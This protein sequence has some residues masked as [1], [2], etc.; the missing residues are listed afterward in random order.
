MWNGKTVEHEVL[1]GGLSN[2][3]YTCCV[4][5]GEKYVL[6]IPGEETDLFIDRTNEQAAIRA[7][8]GI[9]VS[10]GLLSV[11]QPENVT[12]LSFVDG[13][14]MSQEKI[15]GDNVLIEKIIK[16]LK[17]VHTETIFQEETYVFDMIR[18]YTDYSRQ[19]GAFFPHDF[20]WM[21]QVADQIE[22]AMDR[23]KPKLAA[24]HNDLLSENFI[25]DASGK[26]LI[27]DWEYCG[28]NDPYFDLGD[29]C[30]EHPL[31]SNQ[32]EFVVKT[33]N[34]EME[35]SLLYRTRLHKLT[36]DLWWSLWAMIQDKVSNLDFNFYDYGL[37]RYARFRRNYYNPDFATWLAGV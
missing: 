20:D 33:Y 23:N 25:L 11:L 13:D 3:N 24:C 21:C 16:V 27:L 37:G 12:V 8:S 5:N 2:H 36:A 26:M 28:M 32:E 29:F 31:T 9:G 35:T 18:K 7:T 17:R 34:G 1:S 22:L 10:A 30:V 14:V 15:A 6:R 19:K 4:T